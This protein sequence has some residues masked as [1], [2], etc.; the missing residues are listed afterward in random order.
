MGLRSG[1]LIPSSGTKTMFS[2]VDLVVQFLAVGQES[3]WWQ[4][5]EC[6]IWCTS[7]FGVRAVFMDGSY[8]IVCAVCGLLLSSVALFCLSG[9][10]AAAAYSLRDCTV[11]ARVSSF[12]KILFGVGAPGARDNRLSW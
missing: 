2:V 5:V 11:K 8:C 10:C 9:V 12:I 1:L 7:A 4:P 6:S 3:W